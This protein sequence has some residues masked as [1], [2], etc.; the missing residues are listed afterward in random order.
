MRA[1]LCVWKPREAQA[2]WG[3]GRLE[4]QGT[5]T[6]QLEC[7]TP[8]SS[9]E[10]SRPAPAPSPDWV[11][12]TTEQRA[13]CSPH[14]HLGMTSQQDLSVCPSAWVLWPSDGCVFLLQLALTPPADL[15]K[16]GVTALP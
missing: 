5:D 10:V 3:G 4:T 9:G 6:A 11:R 1:H 7:R 14:C 12:P 13:I 15:L 2:L 8:S 16:D